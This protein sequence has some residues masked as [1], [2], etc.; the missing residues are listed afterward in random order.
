[1]NWIFKNLFRL[2]WTECVGKYVVFHYAA[3][4][5]KSKDNNNKIEKK[6][7]VG[8]YHSRPT[9]QPPQ[10]RNDNKKWFLLLDCNAS[11]KI[12]FD[13]HNFYYILLYCYQNC[14]HIVYGSIH[15]WWHH[16]SDIWWTS[17]KNIIIK[18]SVYMY[19]YK[20]LISF[21]YVPQS[22]GYKILFFLC[23][24]T[25]KKV[26]IDLSKHYSKLKFYE[27]YNLYCHTSIYIHV[28]MND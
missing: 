11:K 20:A 23:T 8:T 27:P 28:Y 2:I 4:S 13:L 3:I 9:M 12:R 22:K 15:A 1:M 7:P 21:F 26:N 25:P 5:R 18:G 19:L 10:R 24:F 16:L 17:Y 6:W 14:G